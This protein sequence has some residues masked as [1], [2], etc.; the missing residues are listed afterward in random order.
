MVGLS[1]KEFD[2]SVWVCLHSTQHREH[3]SLEQSD[4]VEG[5]KDWWCWWV[6]GPIQS[7]KEVGKTQ[8]IHSNSGSFCQSLPEE[9]VNTE[10]SAD[11]CMYAHTLS[12]QACR[13]Q[14][15]NLQLRRRRLAQMCYF[16]HVRCRLCLS[17]LSD[18]LL[19]EKQKCKSGQLAQSTQ[20]GQ[21]IF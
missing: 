3:W 10:Q 13:H 9:S 6:M 16:S 19:L 8:L 1:V 5:W 15:I 17:H 12:K 21:Y 11:T 20:A 2:L 4:R 14:G 18:R 7:P